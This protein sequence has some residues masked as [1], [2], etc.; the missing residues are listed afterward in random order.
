[1]GL[2]KHDGGTGATADS[3]GGQSQK[4]TGWGTRGRRHKPVGGSRVLKA[5]EEEYFSVASSVCKGLPA[6]RYMLS[7]RVTARRNRQ[8]GAPR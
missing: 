2:S 6:T 4:A 1:M 8:S 3:T 5:K 7:H